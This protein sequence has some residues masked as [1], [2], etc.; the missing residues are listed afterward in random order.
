MPA[1]L[2]QSLR[3]LA[4]AVP[5]PK[6]RLPLTVK[7]N[8]YKSRVTWPPDFTNLPRKH[9]FRFERKYRRRSQ[10]KYFPAWY[11]RTT[12]I[13]QVGG[14]LCTYFG[15]VWGAWVVCMLMN[16]VIAIYAFLFYKW[17]RNEQDREDL[18][19]MYSFREWVFSAFGFWS[20]PDKPKKKREKFDWHKFLFETRS[21]DP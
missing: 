16:L 13:L 8:P 15:G 2:R 3:L 17:D 10:I 1:M 19:W 9:Q 18:E 4:E 5:A 7:N 14:C 12:K 20:D 11:M 21:R 6:A